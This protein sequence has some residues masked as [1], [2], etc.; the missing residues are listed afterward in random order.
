M[1]VKTSSYEVLPELKLPSPS[2][3]AFLS[4]SLRVP[5]TLPLLTTALLTLSILSSTF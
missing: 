3:E 4:P 5:N 1:A 2:E